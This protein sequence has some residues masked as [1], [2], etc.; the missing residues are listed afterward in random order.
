[1]RRL[2]PSTL[3]GQLALLVAAALFVAQAIN[4]ALLYG[5]RRERSL[6]AISGPATARINDAADRLEQG[7]AD[8]RRHWGRRVTVS[9]ESGCSPG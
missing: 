2:W 3:A 1:M 9:E 4:F 5:E 8:G 7:D 6:N